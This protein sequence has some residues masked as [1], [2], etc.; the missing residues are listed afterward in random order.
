MSVSDD[1]ERKLER[2]A[3]AGSSA[4]SGRTLT[5]L[6]GRTLLATLLLEIDETVLADRFR[7]AN[8]AGREIL[9]VA[10]N[11][12]L[13]QVRAPESRQLVGG[14]DS[15]LWQPTDEPDPENVAFLRNFLEGFI[16]DSDRLQI[17][18]APKGAQGGSDFGIS[19]KRLAEEW[20]VALLPPA[21]RPLVE[22]LDAIMSEN[23]EQ[24]VTWV[25]RI[26]GQTECGG[27]ATL[28]EPTETLAQTLERE[29]FATS[30]ALPNLSRDRCV[31]TLDTF[32]KAGNGVIFAAF[33]GILVT[34]LVRPSGL[35]R[36]AR[37]LQETLHGWYGVKPTPV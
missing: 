23:K 12:R 26:D 13:L 2:L 1:L 28:F 8:T 5:P 30:P 31:F 19:A 37:D 14:P 32:G 21:E 35:V 25:R 22:V 24:I 3:S 33:E 15:I 7:V 29:V 34:L 11:R 18:A 16:A 6:G 36:L 20:D 9:V 4:A 27:D 17:F 10:H